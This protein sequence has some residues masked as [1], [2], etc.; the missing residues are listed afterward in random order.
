M[1]LKVNAKT[2][3]NVFIVQCQRLGIW[4]AGIAIPWGSGRGKSGNDAVPHALEFR[5]RLG[6]HVQ[7]A[8]EVVALS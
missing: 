7:E 4:S 3:I 2:G 5:M 8:S 1:H 6:S